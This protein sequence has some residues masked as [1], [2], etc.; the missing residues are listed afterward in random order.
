MAPARSS[1]RTSTTNSG[2]FGICTTTR[3]NGLMPNSSSPH[4]SRC[5]L[6]H[7]SA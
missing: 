5:T 6:S 7:S 2:M 1:A 4:V 3:S